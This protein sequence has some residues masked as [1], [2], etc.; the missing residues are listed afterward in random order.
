MKTT[1]AAGR[2]WHYSHA[3]G[4]NSNEDNGAT[5]GYV[6]PVSVA[7]APDG[8][9]Y[10]LSR[11]SGYQIHRDGSGRP[12]ISRRIGRTTIDERHMGDFARAEFVWPA[13]IAVAA[14]GNVYASDEATNLI[15]FFPPD[16]PFPFPG[17]DEDG[18]AIG[19]WGESGSGEG[20]MDGP[21]GISFDSNDDLYVVDSRNDRVQKFTK[22]GDYLLGWGSSGAAPGRFDRPWGITVDRTGDVYVAD[23]GN[24]RVQKFTA[25]G[26]YVSSFEGTP[27]DG[28]D[29]WHPSD[30]AVDS[31][32]DVY[33]VDWGNR[34]VQ[35]YEPNG[36]IITAFYGDVDKL[37]KAI[38]YVRTRPGFAQRG[39]LG[40][41]PLEAE[42]RF[43][44]PLA[45]EVDRQDRVII[46]DALGRLL[47]YVKDRDYVAPPE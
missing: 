18:E 24:D 29:L 26:D 41:D 1:V 36:D 27:D 35:I 28:G 19:V 4:R 6:F 30:V 2:V 12:D 31:D 45:V 39:D 40:E 44:R 16:R 7:V 10:V 21:S 22:Q 43:Q 38:E 34:R 23:W 8:L 37:S 11:G 13:G 5:G 42:R 14:D 20:Q 47:V 15:K 9:L 3:L 33:I 32:G 25:E 17:Y 46:S